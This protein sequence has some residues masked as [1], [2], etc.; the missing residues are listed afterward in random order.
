MRRK[1]I[2]VEV[3]LPVEGRTFAALAQ[4]LTPEAVAVQTFHAI[5]PGTEV[6]VQ[7]ALPDGV[8]R[9]EGT[10]QRAD[11]GFLTIAFDAV[12]PT[13]RARIARAVGFLSSATA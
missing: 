11:P 9:C 6:V 2:A 7:I 12:S 10:V 13:D 5:P 1:M 4:H 3:L 8:A